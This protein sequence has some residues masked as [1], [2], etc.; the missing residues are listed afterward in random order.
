V[1]TLEEVLGVRVKGVRSKWA[2][3]RTFSPD[4]RPVVGPDDAAD[5]YFWLVGQGGAGIKTA[6]AMARL[7]RSQID[8]EPVPRGLTEAGVHPDE[9]VVSSARRD[10]ST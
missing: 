3:L 10:Q 8:A 4:R 1:D 6:P 2:G 7:L 9:L 5:G